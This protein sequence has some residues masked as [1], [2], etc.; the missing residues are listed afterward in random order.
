VLHKEGPANDLLTKTQG[1]HSHKKKSC[2]PVPPG[3]HPKNVLRGG[4]SQKMSYAALAKT[5][6]QHQKILK[7]SLV[8]RFAR[9]NLP[10]ARFARHFAQ[11][12]HKKMFW[13]LRLRQAPTK[14]V[15]GVTPLCQKAAATLRPK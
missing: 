8:P 10:S 15:C 12:T 3:L 6:T 13:P 7:K 9:Q 5:N 11:K 14:K 1:G 2:W 4:F